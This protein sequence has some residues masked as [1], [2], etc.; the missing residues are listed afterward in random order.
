MAVPTTAYKIQG[1]TAAAAAIVTV[2]IDISQTGGIRFKPATGHPVFITDP[3]ALK[4]FEIALGIQF[5]GK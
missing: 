1:Q 2:D 4:L 3:E 5:L